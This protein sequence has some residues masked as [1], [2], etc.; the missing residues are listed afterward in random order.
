MR[1]LQVVNEILV[2]SRELDLEE[3]VIRKLKQVYMERSRDKVIAVRTAAATGLCLL[4]NP[5]SPDDEILTLLNKNMLYE[6]VASIRILYAERILVHPLTA[7]S[8]LSRLRDE[9]IMVR[10]A[11]LKNLK[12]HA[13]I[14][15]LS[16]KMRH[17]ILHSLQDRNEVVVRATEAILI[18]NWCAKND[19]LIV[20]SLLDVEEDE[21]AGELFLNAVFSYESNRHTSIFTEKASISVTQL[22]SLTSFYL[23]SAVRYFFENQLESSIDRL[24]SDVPIFCGIIRDAVSS[25]DTDKIV[26]RNMIQCLQYLDVSDEICKNEILHLVRHIFAIPTGIRMDLVI[27]SEHVHMLLQALLNLLDGEASFLR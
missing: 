8:I 17:T 25:E 9:D 10:L 24:I 2:H 13:L 3:R 26:F 22:T 18:D 6:P 23:Y 4:Q 7:E 21:T 14:Q 12:D 11:V 15:Q 5:L 20:L 19:L 1:C 27:D 16:I